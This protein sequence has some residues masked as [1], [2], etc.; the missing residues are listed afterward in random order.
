M[1]NV[2]VRPHRR[3][4]R[5]KPAPSPPAIT[6]ME[7]ARVQRAHHVVAHQTMK[8]IYP[9]TEARD[10]GTVYKSIG[11]E[12][13]FGVILTWLKLIALNEA[14]GQPWGDLYDAA[15]DDTRLDGQDQ[16]VLAE[17]VLT[18]Q[19]R[20]LR[21]PDA[22]TSAETEREYAQLLIDFQVDPA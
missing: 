4:L 21:G 5:S 22:R 12:V 13:K 2:R 10:W 7:A 17:L 15:M 18:M 19:E 1:R 6:T 8:R 14:D 20:S 9:T 11:E 3:K 16:E